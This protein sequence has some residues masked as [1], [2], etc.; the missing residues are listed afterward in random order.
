[1]SLTLG[2]D[3]LNS[4]YPLPAQVNMGIVYL[5]YILPT[6]SRISNRMSTGKFCNAIS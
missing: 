4:S 5:N 1:M 6:C 3:D 2:I